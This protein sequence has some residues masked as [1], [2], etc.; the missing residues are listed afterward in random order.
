MLINSCAIRSAVYLHFLALT[1]PCIQSP[2]LVLI[3]RHGVNIGRRDRQID[4]I[5]ANGAHAAYPIQD[6]V[7]QLA[8]SEQRARDPSTGVAATK[9]KHTALA[10]KRTLIRTLGHIVY[11]A[12]LRE[13]EH[14]VLGNV[15]PGRHGG[16]HS[17]RA[18]EAVDQD[19]RRVAVLGALRGWQRAGRVGRD[20]D[21][22]GAARGSERLAVDEA[23]VRG[24]EQS[25]CSAAGLTGG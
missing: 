21:V 12:G 5:R 20:A 6:L 16:V 4:R 10:I 19:G 7:R 11:L 18:A 15:H 8:G 22:E 14:A 17:D 9:V 23:G 1:S 13:A 2:L 24:R 3:R 25:A